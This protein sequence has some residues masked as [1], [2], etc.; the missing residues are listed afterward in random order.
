MR[1]NIIYLHTHDSGRYWSPYGY[2]VP[3][4]NL[5]DFA[6][7]CTL[8]RQ[9]YSS[10][11]TC[12]PSRAC[13]LTGMTPHESGM[14]GLAS[15][16]WQLNDYRCHMARYL[17]SYG[18]HTVLCGIQ[19]EAPDYHMIGYSEVIGSQDF[20]MDRT[21]ASMEDWDYANTDAAVSFI[22]SYDGNEPLFLSVGL[23][24][25][26]R[27]YPKAKKDINPDYIQPPAVLYDCAKTREDMADYMESARVADTC[28]GRL[29]D[30]LRA[31]GYLE[32]S[33]ILVTTDH[34]IAF[35]D[36]K[37]TLYDTGIGVACMISV[38]GNKLKGRATDA[39]VSHYDIYPTVCEFAGIPIPEWTEGYSLMPFL[40]G[41][42]EKVRDEVFG[43]ITYH[44]SY[45]PERCIRTERYKLIRRFDYHENIVPANIDESLSKDFEMEAGLLRGIHERE[46]LYDLWLD[47]VERTNLVGNADYKDVYD[48]LSA[49]LHSWMEKTDDPLCHYRYR[50]PKP[51]NARVNKLTCMNPRLEDFEAPESSDYDY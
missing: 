46:E 34:G 33:L 40:K 14:Q 3:T 24:N 47:P 28:F 13:L 32:E 49:R 38:P 23:F 5:M 50:V 22:S 12:S 6:S 36:M 18:Y 35:P 17:G 37:C 21:E 7:E 30:A 51:R 44:A 10:A 45:E 29:F 9:C 26:H 15:R 4:P 19:H 1:K 41:E 25:T 31:K 11:P 2:N 42:T 39:L 8:F 16:G 43:E 20:S 27:E 48:D